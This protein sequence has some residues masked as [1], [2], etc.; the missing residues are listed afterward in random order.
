[1]IIPAIPTSAFKV[2]GYILVAAVIVAAILTALHFLPGCMSAPKREFY[3]CDECFTAMDC[4]YRLKD[5]KDKA[6]CAQLIEACRD[7]LKEGRIRSRMEYC[8]GK[9]PAGISEAECRL[10]LNQK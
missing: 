9:K 1:M 4:L 10:L 2:L 6:A 8:S 5:D 7:T 3:S